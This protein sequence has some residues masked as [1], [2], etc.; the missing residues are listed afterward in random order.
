[1][2]AARSRRRRRLY[3]NRRCTPKQTALVCSVRLGSTRLDSARL[4][5]I[6]SFSLLTAGPSSRLFVFLLRRL[7]RFRRGP[8]WRDRTEC[9]RFPSRARLRRIDTQ[10]RCVAVPSPGNYS[11]RS[12]FHGAESQMDHYAGRATEPC[13]TEENGKRASGR[14][15]E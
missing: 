4:G 12:V 1:M 6:Y 3:I 5:N 7:S 14:A 2:R 15:G 10:S 13:E 8:A 9:T 11:A